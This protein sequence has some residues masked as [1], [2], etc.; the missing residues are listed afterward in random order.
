MLYQ[1]SLVYITSFDSLSFFFGIR[2]IYCQKKH[3][4]TSRSKIQ[5]QTDK[6]KASKTKYSYY[7]T[8]WVFY[9]FSL[10]FLFFSFSLS[11]CFLVYCFFMLLFIVL[12]HKRLIAFSH[13]MITTGLETR[14]KWDFFDQIL[15]CQSE[16]VW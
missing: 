14:M 8:S 15:N 2:N 16:P 5:V 9:S 13:K 3:Y 11:Y 4:K 12:A 6:S 7:S 1:F 10:F